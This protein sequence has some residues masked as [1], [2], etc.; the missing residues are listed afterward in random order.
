LQ[1]YS[2]EA[3]QN[4]SYDLANSAGVATDQDAGVTAQFYDT[5]T[6]DFTT[7]YVECLDVPLT[8]GLNTITI[9]ASDLAGNTTTVTF[10]ITLD[11][12]SRINP[13]VVKLYWPQDGTLIA[14]STYTW[15]GWVDDPM[16]AV[17]AQLVDPNGDTNLLQGLVER[18]GK[19]WVENI[20][21]T[22]GANALTLTV[23][24]SAGNV[25]VTNILVYPG[26]VDL[27]IDTPPSDQLW[28][29]TVTVNGAI[30]DSANYTVWVNGRKA[31]LNGDQTWTATNVYLP[32]G[33]TALIQAR[34]I[35][36]SDSDKDGNGTGGTGGGPTTYDN[37]GN[38]AS[39]AASNA[40]SQANKP[41]RLYV[42]MY[43]QPS[44]TT[45]DYWHDTDWYLDGTL[46]DDL[47]GKGDT[48]CDYNWT[49]GSGGSG[50][51]SASG[52]VTGY[53][54]GVQIDSSWSWTSQQTWPPS[55]WP[56]LV[57]GTQTASGDYD[58]P[59]FG[60]NIPP[61]SIYLEHCNI[62]FPI[63]TVVS[64]ALRPFYET[65]LYWDSTE[66]YRY[67]RIADVQYMLE[68][69]GK[70][71][72]GRRDLWNLS[73]SATQ[74]IPRAEGPKSVALDSQPIS[75]QSIIIDG[76]RLGSDGQLWR[77]YAQC[78]T[79]DV[80]VHVPGVDYFT[81]NLLPQKYHP[82]ITLIDTCTSPTSNLDTDTPEVCVGDL[83]YLSLDW[84]ITPP[85]VIDTQQRWKL[86]PKL[87]NEFYEYSANCTS[88]RLNTDLWTNNP[89][90]CWYVNKPGGR[91][92]V[93]Q[94]LHFSNGQY[95]TIAADGNFTVYRPSIELEPL[96]PDQQDRYYTIDDENEVTCFLKLG[97]NDESGKGTMRFVVD[98]RSK[99]SGAIGLTQLITADYSDWLGWVFSD[100]RCD[101]GEWYSGPNDFPGGNY[102]VPNGFVSLD[103]GPNEVWV[104]P[105]IVS[106]SA[107]DFVRFTPSCGI[108]VTLGILTW[109]TVGVAQE[110][111]G[112]WPYW[113]ITEDET[114]GPDGPDSSDEFPK[115]TINQGGQ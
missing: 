86:P 48:C 55:S 53:S 8:D 7:N 36:H 110:L 51:D 103:D 15:R 22:D 95:A 96:T 56:F 98:I 6:L 60:P 67:T 69:G 57:P 54:D 10:S 77:T 2:P 71:L 9:H 97:E 13:P 50:S 89:T 65:Y 62:S 21:L 105:N 93:W 30:S 92:L 16:A 27:S 45:S 37:L 91:V 107:R 81:F 61:P 46:Y 90:W 106:L 32:A 58:W 66:N 14:N 78:D 87:V 94:S 70:G 5:N 101:R 41:E 39:P 109:E 73:A 104:T 43:L 38:P 108:P 19:F 115:W 4:I 85:T 20:P 63:N 23:T 3:L 83:V 112:S 59:N 68:T 72:P 113:E 79:R 49:D 17:T 52:S 25:A 18:D 84:D 80:T 11:Y 33:G 76:K 82:H 75:S 47:V 111:L 40:E 42:Q 100:E 88:Y 102:S 34:A 28:N 74:W 114:T 1:G 99:Y 44:S 35:P 12:S 29:T 64:G 26:T 24:D 31:H